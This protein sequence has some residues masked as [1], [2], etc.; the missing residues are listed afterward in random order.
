MSRAIQ[1]L[2]TARRT[3]QALVAELQRELQRD[4][5]ITG[6]QVVETLKNAD[7]WLGEWVDIQ[8]TKEIQ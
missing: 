8:Q 3:V 1:K 4:Y 5:S 6:E 2:W 7:D